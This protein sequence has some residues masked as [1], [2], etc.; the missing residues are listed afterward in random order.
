MDNSNRDKLSL[1]DIYYYRQ[2][3]KN[4]VHSIVVQLFSKLVEKDGLT[5]A[6]IAYRLGKSPAQITRWFS[7]PSNWTLDTVSDLLLAM[8]AELDSAASSINE[9]PKHSVDHP[10]CEVGATSQVVDFEEEGNFQ[11]QW[12]STHKATQVEAWLS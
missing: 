5:K 3:H 7:G 11:P 1:E 6:A 4:R 8:G 10:L 2:R 12:T 9:K